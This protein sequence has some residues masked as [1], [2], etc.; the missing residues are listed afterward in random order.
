MTR[1]PIP[2]PPPSGPAKAQYVRALF[3]HIVERYDLLNDLMTAGRHHQWRRAAARAAL[4][5]GAL[6]LD[7]GTGTGDLALEL[8]RQGARRV[9]AI[10]F[11]PAMVRAA[12]RKAV[13]RGMAGIHV[14]IGDALAL[15]FPDQTFDCVTS[16]FVVR[17]VADPAAAF[18]EMYRVLRPG[19]RVVCL[20]TSRPRA[21]LTRVLIRAFGLLARLLGRLVARDVAAYG[22]LPAS[23]ATFADADELAALMQR[24]AFS[25]IRYRRVA[26]GLV[27][28]HRALREGLLPSRPTTP[29]SVPREM[30]GD[31]A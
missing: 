28:I 17:N 4:P 14:L 12:R 16:G 30:P 1:M 11:V 10:D 13:R 25:S 9:V 5:A 23:V 26:L 7:L 27:T 2:L 3:S 29:A 19:G 24:A 6:A 20:E 8:A 15:P 18:A 21:R 31:H 22:Y